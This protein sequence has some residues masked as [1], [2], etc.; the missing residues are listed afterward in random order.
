M[1]TAASKLGSENDVRGSN[2]SWGMAVVD[3][4]SREEKSKGGM[5]SRIGKGV[6]G[7]H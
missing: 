7:P 3:E 4:K 2:G 6:V 1:P 5:A